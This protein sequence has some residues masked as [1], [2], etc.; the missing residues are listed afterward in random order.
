MKTSLSL[1]AFALIASTLPAQTEPRDEVSATP[2]PG[3]PL[4]EGT[5]KPIGAIVPA[6]DDKLVLQVRP[7]EAIIRSDALLK[8]NVTYQ[9][10]APHIPWQK[11]SPGGRRGL[12]V[13]LEGNRVL[14]TAQ[15][16]ADATYI[17]LE[18]AEGGQ[19]IPAK[20]LGVDYEANLALIG[21]AT[22]GDRAKGFFTGLKPMSIEPKAEV[23]ENLNIWQRLAQLGN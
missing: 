5:E 1:L 11:E 21:A 18:L 8:V 6:P 19:K 15:M 10:Y 7:R 22:N 23:G 17:E 4:R 9:G 16:V 12:G 2:V 13:I 3:R 20:V 14:V